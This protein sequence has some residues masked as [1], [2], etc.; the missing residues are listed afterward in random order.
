MHVWNLVVP[1][2][3]CSGEVG[4]RCLGALPFTLVASTVALDL[5]LTSITGEQRPLHE[6]V[7][8]F[9]LASVVLDPY[10]NESSWVL[11]TATRVLDAFRGADVRV[12]LIVTCGPEEAKQFLGPLTEQF[13]VF[14]DP[15]RT[16]VKGL[17]L[18]TLPALVFVQGDGNVVAA[19][20]WDPHEWKRVAKHIADTTSW[21][22]PIIPSAGDP[23]PFHGTP[24]LG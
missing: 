5:N 6:W 12:N 1:R 4:R 17:G 13:M 14:C 11:G 10:T 20:G 3:E 7:T 21:L 9:H 24:A 16:F 19:E 8:T 22:A 15:D 2:T 18:G 23:S